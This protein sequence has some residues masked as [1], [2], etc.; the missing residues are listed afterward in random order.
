MMRGILVTVVLIAALAIGFVL[1]RSGAL[2]PRPTPTA[3]PI[4]SDVTSP[5]P[6]TS[7]TPT[8]TAT[9][10]PIEPTPTAAPTPVDTSV[11]ASGVVVP[12]RSAELVARASGVV[13]AIYVHAG[14]AAAANQLLLKLDQRTY[15]AEIRVDQNLVEQAIAAVQQAQLQ[16]DQL[17]P[18][19]S[20]GQIEFVQANVRLAQAEL[21]LARSTLNVA[22][23]ALLQTEIRAPFAG[24]IADLDLEVGE[25]A[26][27]GQPVITI[28]DLSTWLIE[29]IDLS[30]LEVVRVGVGDRASLEFEALPGLIVG[31]TVDSIQ[32]RGTASD[33]G[34]L[35]AVSI[36][37][38]AV[39]PAL[40]WG[41]TAT[42]RIA[43]SG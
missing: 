41:M 43:P 15:Q 36:R 20:P 34:V 25:Q 22:Q 10:T 17:P 37:P 4:S 35:F 1:I 24:V 3:T 29:T 13:D 26:I 18:D 38:D 21:E 7:P 2:D 19:A 42:V 11:V 8:A 5:G 40:R 12:I 6:S 39:D 30:E 33:G 28:G 16:V 14:S 9:I 27:A 32:V 23:N 31:G